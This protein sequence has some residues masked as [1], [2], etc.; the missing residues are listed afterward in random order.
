VQ[1][2]PPA[3]TKSLEVQKR[4]LHLPVRTGAPL[5]QL[6]VTVGDVVHRAFEIELAEGEPDWWAFMDLAAFHGETI[7]VALEGEGTSTALDAIHQSDQIVDEETIYREARRPQLRFSSRRG[8]LNDPNGLVFYEGEYHLFYQDNP[9]GTR[10]ANMHWGRDLHAHGKPVTRAVAV[11]SDRGTS[12]KRYSGN[13]VLPTRG[14]P[15]SSVLTPTRTLAAARTAAR[16]VL[17]D[18]ASTRALR[19]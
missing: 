13:P 8:W 4:Y 6:S 16:S 10:W 5:R 7:T 18:S 17:G 9:Y 14:T 19:P 11:S 15:R 1:E 2:D 3:V 12:W